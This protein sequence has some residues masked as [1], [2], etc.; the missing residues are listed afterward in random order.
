LCSRV[1]AIFAGAIRIPGLGTLSRRQRGV[2][3]HAAN[4]LC[5][6]SL[7]AESS[8]FESSTAWTQLQRH[9]MSSPSSSLTVVSGLYQGLD[10]FAA[11]I[12]FFGVTFSSAI[13]QARAQT[14]LSFLTTSRASM[15]SHRTVYYLILN[16]I[17]RPH[18]GSLMVS[19]Q[20]AFTKALSFPLTHRGVLACLLRCVGGSAIIMVHT[21]IDSSHR[22]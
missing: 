3:L 14:Y 12:W 7:H 6:T 17:E 4:W 11:A 10:A 8:A 19:E 20:K 9:R 1:Q 21:S 16:F 15:A 18:W 13:P 5:W 22:P 2:A